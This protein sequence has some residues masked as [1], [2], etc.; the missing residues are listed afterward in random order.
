MRTTIFLGLTLLLACD[1]DGSTAPDG[2]RDA[3]LDAPATDTG[4]DAPDTCSDGRQNGGESDTDCGGPCDACLLDQRCFE[5]TDC[6]SEVCGA[7]GRCIRRECGNETLDGTETDV[8]CGG[9]CDP[10]DAGATCNAESDCTSRLCRENLCREASCG[11]DALDTGETDVDCGGACGVCAAGATCAGNADCRS[12]VCEANACLDGCAATFGVPCEGIEPIYLKDVDTGGLGGAVA[13]AGD[14]LVIGA[15]GTDV[16]AE[17]R[18]VGA[19]SIFH[20]DDGGWV[21]EATILS[22][23]IR[24]QTAFGTDVAL[25]GDTLFVAARQ[26]S[27]A[28]AGIDPEPGGM[29]ERSGAAHVYRRQPDGSWELEATFKSPTPHTDQEF[30]DAVAIEG[31]RIAVGARFEHHPDPGDEP[32]TRAGAVYIYERSGRTWSL[33]MV[34]RPD[35][36]DP[37]D[38]FGTAVAL[39]DDLLVV[40]AV[41]EQSDDYRIGGDQT[42]N[43]QRSGAVYVFRLD[44]DAWVPEVFIK[45]SN[46]GLNDSFGEALAFDGELL[47]VAAHEEDG[48][49]GGVDPPDNN[50][51]LDTGAVYL[52]R[53]S[54]AG[55]WSAESILKSPRPRDEDRFGESL[56]VIDGVVAVGCGEDDGDGAGFDPIDRPSRKNSGA[57]F[58]FRQVEG[59]WEQTLYLKPS[60]TELGDEFGRD[61]ALVDGELLVGTPDEDGS[62]DGVTPPLDDARSGAGAAFL[63][64]FR[65]AR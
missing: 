3:A 12:N 41:T 44:G 62:G 8:D 40:G 2:G 29:L 49:A 31:D 16:D 7:A 64:D 50:L 60:A 57:V 15:A 11:N 20:R 21:P 23:V 28:G 42:R 61:I 63:Y 56:A 45:A 4:P 39:H 54:P 33:S 1:D 38:H 58:F 52:F 22:P 59:A 19:V 43:V 32:N 46:G 37:D 27:Q 35:P 55:E 17:T 13:L 30:G 9:S 65:S 47:A 48:S 51:G 53:R 5:E 34:V 14:T 24:E 18:A 36:H 10:C 26:D 25:S 6:A